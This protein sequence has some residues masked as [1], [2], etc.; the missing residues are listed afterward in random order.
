[1]DHRSVGANG[2]QNDGHGSAYFANC[3]HYVFS[4]TLQRMIVPREFMVRRVM[5][6]VQRSL[7]I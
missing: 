2:A 7:R 1:M 5:A 6:T 4:E 3:L